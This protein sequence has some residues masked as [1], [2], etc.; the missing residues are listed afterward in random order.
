MKINRM[1]TIFRI[2]RSTLTFIIILQSVQIFGQDDTFIEG[3]LIDA[4]KQT[5]ISFAT[6]IIKNKKRGLISNADGGFRIPYTFKKNTDTLIIS[7]I[8]YLSKEILLS[9]LK[10]DK[11][12]LIKLI[13]KI[14]LLDEVKIVAA[15]TK[16]RKSARKIIRTALDRIPENYPFTPFSY[17]G[18]YRD[19]Q[20]KDGDYLNM[21]EAILKVFDKGFGSEDLKTTETSLYSYK[22]NIDFPKDT[23]ASRPYDYINRSKIISKAT[24]DGQ[25][26]NEYTILRLHDA[27]R[28]HNI[29]AYDFVNRLNKDL[30]RSHRFKLLPETSINGVSLY[31]IKILKNKENIKVEGRIY[32]SKGDFKIYKMEYAVYDRE[33]SSISGEQSDNIEILKKNQGKLLFEII[34]EYR[35]NNNLMY[36]NYISFN[37]T[38]EVLQPPKFKPIAAKINH[39]KKRFELIFNNTPFLKDAVKKSNYRLWYKEIKLRIDSIAVKKKAVHLY[40]EDKKAFFLP[41]MIQS[42]NKS[43]SKGVSIEVKN[44]KD[45]YGNIVY[46]QESVSYNQFREF[47][48]Q[49]LNNVSTKSENTSFMIKTKPI[50]KN[51]QPITTPENVSEYWMNTPLK[52]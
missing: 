8:G 10:E 18:Y 36:P 37:N 48:V 38:F 13:E 49:E 9:N 24:L 16:R 33:K 12:N 35:A 25:G 34:V 21:N 15:K 31:A 5:P 41:K 17:V 46:E 40:P 50:S 28:N 11:V 3:K 29:N 51:Y 2:I 14:E 39:E 22:N 45:I 42:F 52:N 30:I 47:F 44:V 43:S 20:I 1:Y 32:I 23:I 19:Y 26:G 7:S 27:I 4:K 6:V